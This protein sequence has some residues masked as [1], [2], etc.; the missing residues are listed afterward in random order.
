METSD[1]AQLTRTQEARVDKMDNEVGRLKYESQQMRS[2]LA[3]LRG[4][5]NKLSKE[6]GYNPI[7]IQ[8]CLT[9][10]TSLTTS[11]ITC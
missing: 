3:D 5:L 8:S 7:L 10:D 11:L 4:Q 9:I 1:L 6:V 2:M